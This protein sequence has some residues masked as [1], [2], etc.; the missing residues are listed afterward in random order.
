[1]V[2]PD[3][4][5][6]WEKGAIVSVADRRQFLLI[7]MP[8]GLWIDLRPFATRMGERGVRLILAHP[9]RHPEFLHDAGTIE[10]HIEAGCLVQVSARS[11]THPR[12]AADE[13]ALKAW[14][15]RGIVHV[16]GSDGH[17]TTRRPPK[18]ADAVAV[19]RH[20][21][22]DAAADRIGSTHGLAVLQGLPLRVP[23]PEPPGR[24]WLRAWW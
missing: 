20:W 12:D 1:M 6:D 23:P 3:L 21:A 17:S 13:K 10:G 4:E 11:L 19:I 24:R 18:L 14:V 2:R 16:L 5:V 7:E 9:E 8:H 22:G 15:K